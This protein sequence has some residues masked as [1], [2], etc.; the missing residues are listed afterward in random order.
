MQVWN[1]ILQRR[2]DKERTSNY[3]NLLTKQVTHGLIIQDTKHP[4]FTYS[5]KSKGHILWERV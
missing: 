1:Q 4:S 2:K 5:I 3:I